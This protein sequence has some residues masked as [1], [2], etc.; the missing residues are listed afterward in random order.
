MFRSENRKKPSVTIN[1]ICVRLRCSNQLKKSM[2]QKRAIRRQSFKTN[3]AFR[4]APFV[5]LTT[6][7]SYRSW[8]GMTCSNVAALYITLYGH[9]I[10]LV[11]SNRSSFVSTRQSNSEQSLELGIDSSSSR[12]GV[13]MNGGNGHSS[14]TSVRYTGTLR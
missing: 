7:E 12:V 9:S 6:Y 14:A 4:C 11:H 2:I 5:I 10:G 8:S 13:S 3:C 1:F